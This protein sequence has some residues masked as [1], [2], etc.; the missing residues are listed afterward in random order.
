MKKEHFKKELNVIRYSII[1]STLFYFSL[2]SLLNL[3]N[4]T[5][6]KLI[7]ILITTAIIFLIN[8]TIIFN[9]YV[10]NIKVNDDFLH[11]LKTNLF[12]KKSKLILPIQDLEKIKNRTCKNNLYGN[13]WLHCTDA[14]INFK[15]IGL[16]R[17]NKLYR[18]L[19]VEQL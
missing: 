3:I 19:N 17:K 12:G 8:L 2:L 5:D 10:Y 13:L 6:L 15:T 4:L 14:I 16:A 11:I 18:Q 7:S 1:F 9:K